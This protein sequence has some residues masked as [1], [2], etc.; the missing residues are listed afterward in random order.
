MAPGS[1]A[2]AVDARLICTVTA[3]G[4]VSRSAPP[5]TFVRFLAHSAENGALIRHT[6]TV[7]D[8][9][10][11]KPWINGPLR[12]PHGLTNVACTT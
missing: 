10:T 11:S 7:H 2:I 12:P 9:G 6:A 8:D 5:S 4:A 1:P 3:I